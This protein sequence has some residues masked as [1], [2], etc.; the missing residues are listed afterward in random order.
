MA[1]IRAMTS[2]TG[3]FSDS[4]MSR[5]STSAETPT[6]KA[7]AKLIEAFGITDGQLGPNDDVA[8]GP[9]K[10]QMR[11]ELQSPVFLNS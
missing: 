3:S 6:P 10:V 11:Q 2:A 7:E 5:Y 9:G 1:F 4:S 8:N